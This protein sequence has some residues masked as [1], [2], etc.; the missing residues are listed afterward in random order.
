MFLHL[1]WPFFLNSGPQVKEGNFLE[2]G[3]YNQDLINNLYCILKIDFT[4]ESGGT[5]AVH[6][7]DPLVS[8]V[9]LTFIS[10]MPLKL[11]KAT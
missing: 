8:T 9:I 3:I 2:S 11:S 7:F 4:R 10:V 1:I 6:L 5:K